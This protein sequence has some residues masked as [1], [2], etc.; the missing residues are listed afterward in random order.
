MLSVIILLTIFWY[1]P[2]VA[3][4]TKQPEKFGVVL[5]AHG[6][7]NPELDCNS[8]VQALY[9]K[10][11]RDDPSL[12]LELAFL[13][14]ANKKT[15]KDAVNN[16]QAQGIKDNI[17][18]IHLSPSSFSIRHIELTES[19]AETIAPEKKV[20]IKKPWSYKQVLASYALPAM[21][22]AVSPAMDDNPII[23][24]ILSDQAK[25][26]LNR[27]SQEILRNPESASLL[28]VSY[29]A[30]DELE[31]ILWNRQMEQIGEAIK[32]KIGFRSVACISLRNHSADLIREQAIIELIK[33][34]KSLKDQGRVIV[35]PYV[36]CAGAFQQSLQSY[37]GGI[38]PPEDI[39]SKSVITD[40]DAVVLWV[41]NVIARGMNQPA[42]PSVNRNWSLMDIEKGDKIGTNKYGVCEN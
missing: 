42:S 12:K 39:S 28:L 11:K 15:L 32:S 9:E 8:Q 10:I 21:R 40:L 18:I 38:I 22:Y 19:I 23:I 26:I 16:L 14:Y 30:I 41:R 17:L 27:P 24:N 20:M 7:N 4:M 3:E 35:V 36:L 25:E 33:T 5:V 6:S 2:A 31:N 1:S 37:L 13:R 29:G 34:A